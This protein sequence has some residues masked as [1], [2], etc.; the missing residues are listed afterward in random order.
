MTTF[1]PTLASRRNFLKA[2]SLTVV[3]SLSPLNPIAAQTPA[4]PAPQPLPGSLN[5]NRM[6]DGWLRINADGTY[7]NHRR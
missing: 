6:L 2:T 7:A 3:F 1:T 5:S 4:G